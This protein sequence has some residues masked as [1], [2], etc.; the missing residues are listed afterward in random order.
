[1]ERKSRRD[2]DPKI[3]VI[4]EE[5]RERRIKN[6]LAS[7]FYARNF[8][9]SR[10]S[11]SSSSS[12]WITDRIVSAIINSEWWSHARPW[13]SP[14]P[15]SDA[16]RSGTT[17]EFIKRAKKSSQSRRVQRIELK[18]APPR[19]L[20]L[21]KEK[22]YDR[23]RCVIARIRS[24]ISWRR[25]EWNRPWTEPFTHV[26][27][28]VEWEWEEFREIFLSLYR[29]SI[30]GETVEWVKKEIVYFSIRERDHWSNNSVFLTFG[31]KNFRI[32][33]MHGKIYL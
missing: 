30:F 1:M 28:H 22:T 24:M 23:N 13:Y 9:A 2:R 26:E 5:E 14:P 16:A 17:V 19:Q 31:T 8:I 32:K 27:L 4:P 18:C 7:D 6:S 20:D 29:V 21:K 25:A 15:P 33:I 12:S 10:S 11:S 3:P